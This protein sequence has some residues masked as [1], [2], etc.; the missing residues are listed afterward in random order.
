MNSSFCCFARKHA[1]Q[2]TT[3]QK[4]FQSKR[5]P[6]EEITSH[7]SNTPQLQQECWCFFSYSQ[8][9]RLKS[10]HENQLIFAFFAPSIKRFNVGKVGISNILF[11]VS[12]FSEFQDYIR[13][14]FVLHMFCMASAHI[15]HHLCDTSSQEKLVLKSSNHI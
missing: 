13:T 15:C 6:D 10:S 5:L 12:L 7:S 14:V 3:V 2:Q 1:C 9:E 11:L 8:R 4:P